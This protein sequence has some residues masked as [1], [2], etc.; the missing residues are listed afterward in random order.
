VAYELREGRG[1][2]FANVSKR[3]AS[4]PDFT[5]KVRIGGVS[6][7]LSAWE[8][9]SRTGVSWISLSADQLLTDASPGLK[10]DAKATE[11]PA[12]PILS[13]GAPHGTAQHEVDDAPPF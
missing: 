7:R 10:P 6:Y 2:L 4:Q 12:A 9:K 8:K 5:G 1:S 3:D 13:P 11:K